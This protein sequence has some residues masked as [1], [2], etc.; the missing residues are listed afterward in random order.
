[1]TLSLGPA[2]GKDT[3]HQLRALAGHPRRAEPS[4]GPGQRLRLT[5]TADVN[6]RGLQHAATSTDLYWSFGEMI[7]YASRGTES[8]PATSS[9]AA[10][11][12]PAASWSSPGSTGRRLPVARRRRRGPPGDRRA[13]LDHHRISPATATPSR[14]S[15]PA[16]ESHSGVSAG[17]HPG[18]TSRCS[19]RF[20]PGQTNTTATRVM[21]IGGGQVTPSRNGCAARRRDHRRR[22]QPS[23]LRRLLVARQIRVRIGCPG[24]LQ[25]LEVLLGCRWSR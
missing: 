24:P 2:K 20:S 4:R 14:W 5:M 16:H 11:S 25:Q 12:A 21:I 1:M 9:A 17:F 10:P 7:A 8:D 13:R 3:R 22:R 23:G 19:N 6:G 18:C 15:E